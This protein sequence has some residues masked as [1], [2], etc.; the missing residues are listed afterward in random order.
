[1]GRRQRAADGVRRRQG[2]RSPIAAFWPSRWDCRKAPSA[3]SRTTSAAASACAA[4]SI[5]RIFSFRLRRGCLDRPVKWI[6]DRR[7]NL[8]ATNHARDAECEL[9]IACKRDGT[10]PR[11][12]R[13]RLCRHRRL[14]PHR[15][16]DRRAQH[17]A[18][19]VRAVQH[20][21][22]PHRH[23]AAGD[24]QDAGRHL[25]RA[26]AATRPISSASGCSTSRREISESTASNS[27]GAT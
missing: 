6:E 23:L 14:Y 4:N 20:P 13:P 15:R 16:R 11:P 9:E 5:R 17:R 19:D 27:V 10:H 7:E 22:H 2:R 8:L 1:M 24:Q 21:E 26:R 25:S 18:G 3:W 12:A